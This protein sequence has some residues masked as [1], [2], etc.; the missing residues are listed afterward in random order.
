[1]RKRVHREIFF[2]TC[3]LLA[4]FLPVYP[5]ILP[6]I[7][8]VMI[9][10]WLISGIYLTTIPEL[11]KAKW[12]FMTLS[13]AS[14][15]LLYV[16]GMLYSTDYEYGWFDLEVKLSLLIFPLIFATCDQDIYNGHR[17]RLLFISFIAGCFAGSLLLL[18]HTWLVHER[19]GVEN[20]FYYTNLTWYFHSSYLAMYYTFGIAVALFYLANDLPKQPVQKSIALFLIVFYLQAF[21]FL[22]SSKAGLLTLIATEILFVLLL[23]SRKAG[24]ARII[25]VSVVLMMLFECHE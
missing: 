7:I 19:W 17:I 8:V 12:R 1:M 2:I 9:V 21:I 13:F 4:F 14:L 24:I 3:L 23:I 18:G 11:F 25:M 15:Y 22:L 16:F 6:S 10:N 20:A 5:R